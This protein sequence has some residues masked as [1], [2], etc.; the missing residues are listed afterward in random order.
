MRRAAIRV[1]VPAVWL[2]VLLSTSL[3]V[4][5]ADAADAPGSTGPWGVG[6]RQLA[7]VDA[8]RGDRPLPLEVWYPVNPP[9]VTGPF[10]RY[11][12]LPPKS[13]LG[14]NSA[15]A[16][17]GALVSNAGV[18]PLVVFSH[19]SGGIAIQ[20][21]R[22]MEQLASHGFVVVAPSHTGNTNADFVGGT[23][24]PIAQALLDRVP[25]VSFVIDHMTALAATPGDPFFGRIDGQNVGVAGHSLGG[26]TAL[27]VKSGY[28]GIPPDAR[29]RAIMPIAPAASAITDAE[30]AGIM[31]PTLFMTGTLDGLLAQ[32]IRAAG[33]IHAG[34]FNYR[35]DV[36]GATH[37][38]F[39]NICDIAN[40]LIAVGIVPRLWPLFGAAALLGPYNATCIPPAFS[41]EEATRLQNLYATAFFRRHLWRELFYDEFLLTGYAEAHEPAV[42]FTVTAACGNG[43]TTEDTDADGV[44]DACDNCIL[45]ANADQRDADGEGFGNACDADLNND[46]VVNFGDLAL[47]KKVL[48]KTDAV[49]DLNGDGVVD[50]AD[51]AIMKKGFF[52]APGPAADKP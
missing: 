19:G 41:I 10:T 4:G 26:F 2:A 8:S 31:V 36:I 48:F 12:L 6:H 5:P 40:V 50:F 32:E 38:H 27:A 39:A 15:L 33:L 42:E 23:A 30:L 28:Q 44:G 52:K 14:L 24:V 35:A 9:D 20:S 18:R 29:V 21:I 51:L 3:G 43:I 17:E 47:M 7:S 37:T 34:P 11:L 16:H 22:L 25:D 45:V 46:G 13:P 1:G 49:A